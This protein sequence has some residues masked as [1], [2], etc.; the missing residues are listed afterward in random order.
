[1]LF[2][3]LIF[4]QRLLHG[5]IPLGAYLVPSMGSLIR[6]SLLAQGLLL[7]LAPDQAPKLVPFFAVSYN[8]ECG[9]QSQGTTQSQK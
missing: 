1:M 3:E 8:Q 6:V 2:L 9:H 5:F 4:V 7:T